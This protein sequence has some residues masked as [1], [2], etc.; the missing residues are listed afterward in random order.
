MHQVLDNFWSPASCFGLVEWAESQSFADKIQKPLWERGSDAMIVFE[1]QQLA[2]A[3]FEKIIKKLPKEN[4]FGRLT[5]IDDYLRLFRFDSGLHFFNP[6]DL[7]RSRNE[8]IF[9]RVFVMLNS[10]SELKDF[11]ISAASGM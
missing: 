10:Q 7:T 8:K 11:S 6:N 2:D 4:S 1:D 9:Y 5:G 3:M